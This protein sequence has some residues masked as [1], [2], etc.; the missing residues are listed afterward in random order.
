MTLGEG[1][2]LGKE[3]DQEEEAEEE[4]KRKQDRDVWAWPC[5]NGGSNQD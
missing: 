3:E 4:R 2:E 5:K 1:G